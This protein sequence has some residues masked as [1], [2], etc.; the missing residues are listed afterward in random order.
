MMDPS[1]ETGTL[2]EFKF[3]MKKIV[4]TW[5]AVGMCHRDIV[6]AK[7]YRFN[8]SNTGHGAYM[9]SSNGGVWSNTRS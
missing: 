2:K 8:F 5:V 9:V 4:S 6:V 1:I 3:K 7:D